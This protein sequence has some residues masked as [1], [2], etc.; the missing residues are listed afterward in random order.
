MIK[1]KLAAAAGAFVM[2][3]LIAFAVRE[4]R[5]LGIK[6]DLRAGVVS[7]WWEKAFTHFD[8]ARTHNGEEHRSNGRQKRE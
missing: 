8:E 2:V 6:C 3:P 4:G 5:F 7:C 1:V